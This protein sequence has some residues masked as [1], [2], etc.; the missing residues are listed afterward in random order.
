MRFN[1]LST[2]TLLSAAVVGVFADDNLQQIVEKMPGCA[3]SCYADATTKSGCNPGTSTASATATCGYPPEWWRAWGTP[4][5][6]ILVSSKNKLHQKAHLP[7]PHATAA[8]GD[9]CS[10]MYENPPATEVEAASRAVTQ[11]VSAATKMSGAAL[12]SVVG[13]AAVVVAIL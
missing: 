1:I 9:I 10:R 2:I 6:L 4:T 8:V 12:G 3:V 11:A 5:A 7:G 13:A